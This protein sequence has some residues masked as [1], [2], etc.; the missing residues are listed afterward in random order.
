M[1]NQIKPRLLS[2]TSNFLSVTFI[3]E[4]VFPLLSNTNTQHGHCVSAA[5]GQVKSELPFL[6]Q[7][8]KAN[9]I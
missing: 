5:V 6:L 4:L 2:L 7:S 8:P 1:T 3:F 9:Y